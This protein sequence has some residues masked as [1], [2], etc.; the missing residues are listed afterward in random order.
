[1]EENK[2]ELQEAINT[3]RKFMKQLTIPDEMLQQVAEISEILALVSELA[4]SQVVLNHIHSEV[5][6]LKEI[7]KGYYY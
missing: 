4:K 3:M 2:K 5:R 7:L 6:G 1:M